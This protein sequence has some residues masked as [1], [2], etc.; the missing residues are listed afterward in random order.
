M[1][2]WADSN[3]KVRVYCA[4]AVN[5]SVVLWFPTHLFLFNNDKCVGAFL[6]VDRHLTRKNS[7]PACRD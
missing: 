3:S 6:D 5:N 1:R 4:R 7:V 2:K